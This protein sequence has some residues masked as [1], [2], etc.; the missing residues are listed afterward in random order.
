M[1]SNLNPSPPRV[2]LKRLS[3]GLDALGVG[4]VLCARDGTVL[5]QSEQARRLLRSSDAEATRET[6]VAMARA[7]CEESQDGPPAP[8]LRHVAHPVEAALAVTVVSVTEGALVAIRPT[9]A[10]LLPEEFLRGYGLTPAEKAVA[11][12]LA[13]RLT[14]KEIAAEMG[15]SPH[16]VKHHV[17]RVLAKLGVSS[18]QE[19]RRVLRRAPR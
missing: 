11:R 17:E 6:L 1:T 12:R 15:T 13:R 14:N 16:T 4:L 18:R 8:T 9:R 3:P 19:V 5:F 10:E 7:A 2:L